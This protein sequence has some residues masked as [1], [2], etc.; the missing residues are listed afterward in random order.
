MNYENMEKMVL[1]LIVWIEKLPLYFLLAQYPM[2]LY[3]C[4]IVVCTKIT[5][6]LGSL[7]G[8]N[9]RGDDIYQHLLWFLPLIEA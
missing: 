6:P 4:Q 7:F 5:I 1:I 8:R 2:N 3:Y 9:P